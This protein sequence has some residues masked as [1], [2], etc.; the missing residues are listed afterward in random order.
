MIKVAIKE[1]ESVDR[2]LKRF[3]RKVEQ[4]GILKEVRKR[5]YFQ[6]PSIKRKVKAR[7]ADARAKKRDKKVFISKV[8]KLDL[9]L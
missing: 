1:G 9:V 7:S 2:A 3:K 5:Q 6:K 4:S 8:P